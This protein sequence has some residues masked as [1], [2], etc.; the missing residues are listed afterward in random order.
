[1]AEIYEKIMDVSTAVLFYKRSLQIVPRQ[2]IKEKI[3]NLTLVK[4]L[5]MLEVGSV[6]NILQDS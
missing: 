5:Q 6:K 2:D 3:Q 1:M 4:G